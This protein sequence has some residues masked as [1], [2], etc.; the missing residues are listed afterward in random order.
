MKM[1]KWIAVILCLT[2]AAALCPTAA[3][4]GDYSSARNGVAVVAV[5]LELDGQMMLHSYGSGFFVDSDDDEVEYLVTNHHVVSDHLTMGSG[6]GQ[7]VELDDGTVVSVRSRLLVFFDEDDYVEAKVVDSNDVDDLALVKISRPTDERKYLTLCPPTDEMQ[8]QS[9]YAIGFPDAAESVGASSQWG[10]NDV[11]IT[12]G[13]ISRLVDETGTLTPLVQTDA[14]I[15]PGNSGGPLVNANGEVLGVNTKGIT[16]IYDSSSR[17]VFY[18]VNVS[19]VIA[20]LQKNAVTF[21]LAGKSGLLDAVP[22]WV[23]IAAG[24]VTVVAAV[25]AVALVLRKKGGKKGGKKAAG[26]V[27]VGTAGELAGRRYPLSGVQLMAGRDTSQCTVLYPKDHPGVSFHHCCL[28][29][30]NGSA[31]IRDVGSTFGTYVNG[32]RLAPGENRP[33]SPGAAISLGSSDETF[34]LTQ[35]GGV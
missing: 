13:S 4:A 24:A 5:V 9:A 27:L 23:W 19:E 15:S 8:G 17:E 31:Y 3:A 11:S 7:N 33:L 2:I 10:V 14:V 32:S 1:K 20:M 26:L 28:W 6:E 29:A 35:E 25:A 12:S 21:K 18:A 16:T 22:S 30:E 34:T